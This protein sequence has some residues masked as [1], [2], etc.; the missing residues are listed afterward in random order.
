[1]QNMVATENGGWGGQMGEVV[2]SRAF[3]LFKKIFGSF[4]ASTAYPEKRGFSLSASKNV[5]RWWCVP[6]GSICPGVKSSPLFHQKQFLNGLNK[7]FYF[8]WE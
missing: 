2:P 6:L 1:M 7:A 8:A 4:N 3:Y 5:F